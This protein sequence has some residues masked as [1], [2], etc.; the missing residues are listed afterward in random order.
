MVVSL[1][2][3]EMWES[4]LCYATLPAII[5]KYGVPVNLIISSIVRGVNEQN[6]ILNKYIRVD[7][8]SKEK[9]ILKLILKYFGQE[10]YL[11]G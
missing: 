1:G 8:W 3:R 9:A 6:T 11:C 7:D 4:F 2:P 10:S 5:D